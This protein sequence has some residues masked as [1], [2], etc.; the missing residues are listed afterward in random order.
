M[1]PQI[2]RFPRYPVQSDNGKRPFG[3]PEPVFVALG[4]NLGDRAENLSVALERIGET[5]SIV[6]VS[7][8]YETEPWGVPDE[9]SAYLNQLCEL[10]SSTPA[11]VLMN[12]LLGIE[13]DL[14]RKRTFQNEARP[15]DLD[16][17]FYGDRVIDVPGLQIPHP[18][19]HE[20]AFVLAPLAEIAPE[21]IHP[22]LGA[23]PG[24]LLRD[25]NASGVRRYTPDSAA[26][27]LASD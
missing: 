10:Q 2:A 21:L 17:L 18:R 4:S 14:G 9:Q 11:S 7:S 16:I 24:D 6:A 15:L 25:V 3:E 8:V 1:V 19:L 27:T 13:S 26:D 20:R 23:T 12:L 22:I 5:E